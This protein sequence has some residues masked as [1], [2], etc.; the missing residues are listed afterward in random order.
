MVIPFI[1]YQ[2]KIKGEFEIHTKQIL[3]SIIILMGKLIYYT[4]VELPLAVV[5]RFVDNSVASEAIL[6]WG[7]HSN[8]GLTRELGG[9][10][11]V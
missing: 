5:S 2:E 10:P 11:G 8:R 1:H 3:F 6:K 7:S 9:S 4:R